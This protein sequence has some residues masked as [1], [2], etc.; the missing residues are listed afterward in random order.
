MHPI[1]QQ[2]VQT[3]VPTPARTLVQHPV[4]LDAATAHHLVRVVQHHVQV[5]AK[6]V[7][8]AHMHVQLAVAAAVGKNAIMVVV[9]LAQ[10]AVQI[11]VA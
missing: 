11:A 8:G 9:D 10:E 1:A 3:H 4:K 7:Q 5:L 2:A 6:V